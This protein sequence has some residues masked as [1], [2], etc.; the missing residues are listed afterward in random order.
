MATID[1][2]ANYTPQSLKT[3]LA[4]TELQAAI[5][6]AVLVTNLSN[7]NRVRWREAATMPQSS[8]EGHFIPP[9]GEKEITIQKSTDVW[10]WVPKRGE[11]AR[12]AM[13]ISQG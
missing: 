12:C 6:F 9:G 7:T 4:V 3:A 13:T 2:T 5:P 10:L 8:D 11:T 1:F